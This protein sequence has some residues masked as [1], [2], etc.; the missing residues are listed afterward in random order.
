MLA[1]HLVLLAIEEQYGTKGRNSQVFCDNKG[2]LF[3]F[4][5][6]HKRVPAGMANSD[7]LRVLRSVKSLTKS[8]LKHKHVK[9]HQDDVVRRGRLALEA[10]LNCICDD[11]AKLATV[12]AMINKVQGPRMDNPRQPLPKEAARVYIG[13]DKQTSALIKSLR[14]HI[15]KTQARELYQKLRIMDGDTF[16]SVAWRDTECALKG[17][18]RMY[19]VWY[20]KQ[21]ADACATG[22]RMVQRNSGKK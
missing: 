14:Y 10:R 5:K 2:A 11:M 17:K 4:G 3:T 7:I 6:T 22:D 1:I 20:G 21:G 18:P 15:G 19:Q 12:R 16:D 9:A 8:I 13:E